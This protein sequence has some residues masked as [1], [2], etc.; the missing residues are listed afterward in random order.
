MFRRWRGRRARQK[1]HAWTANKSR[2]SHCSRL[3]APSPVQKLGAFLH[4]G[5]RMSRKSAP[6]ETKSQKSER[7]LKFSGGGGASGGRADPPSVSDA[8]LPTGLFD[9]DSV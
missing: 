2:A 5:S 1:S 6:A 4:D 9:P 7:I 3:T 8:A